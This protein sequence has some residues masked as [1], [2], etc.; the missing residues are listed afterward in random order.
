MSTDPASP[1]PRAQGPLQNTGAAAGFRVPDLAPL[2]VPRP[3]LTAAL[4]RA[5]GVPLVLVSGPAGSG[6]TSLV[7]EWL[8]HGG[9]RRDAI[10]WV[11]FEDEDTRLWQPLLTALVRLGL[12]LPASIARPVPDQLLGHTRLGALATT[13]A[14]S[15]R[16]WTVVLDGYELR[17]AELAEEVD[18]LLHHSY[19]ALR[20]VVAA[21]V[22]PVLPLYRYRLAEDLVEVRAGDLAFTDEEAAELLR[23]CGTSLGTAGVRALNRRL[24]GWAAGLRFAAR[25]LAAH[26]RPAETAASAIAQDADINAYLVAEVLDGLDPEDRRLLMRTC[27]PD[28]LRPGLAEELAGP[29]AGRELAVL[30]QANLF[31]EPVPEEPGCFRYSPFFRD[32]LRAQLAAEDL[33][34]AAV[35]HRRAATWL[36]EHRMP[37][38]AVAQ[39]A[40]GGLWSDVADRIVEDLLVPGL[41]VGHDERLVTIA[42]EIPADL[43]GPAACAVRAALAL[44]AAD[45]DATAAELGRARA[46]DGPVSHNLSLALTLIDM[47]RG[48]STDPAA[49]AE[50]LVAEARV[51]LDVAGNPAASNAGPGPIAL[52]D[53]AAAIIGLRQGHLGLARAALRRVEDVPGLPSRLGASVLGHRALTDALDGLLTQARR[54]AVRAVALMD[55]AQVAVADRNAAAYVALAVVALERDDLAATAEHLAAARACRSLAAHPVCRTVASGVAAHLEA[56]TRPAGPVV[57]RLVAVSA[58]ALDHDPW[59]AG[60]LRLQAAQIA[61]AHGLADRAVE[62]LDVL[63]REA[64]DTVTEEGLGGTVIAAAASAERAAE[65]STAGPAVHPTL[66]LA[67]SS[68]VSRPLPTEVSR[69]LVEA[70]HESRGR[71][72]QRAVTLVDSALRLASHEQLRRPFREAGPSVRRLLA[73]HP[74]L[75]RRHRWLVPVRVPA[76]VPGVAPGALAGVSSATVPPGRRPPPRAT[77][78]TPPVPVREEPTDVAGLV[79][80]PLTAKEREVLGHLEELLTTEEMAEKMFV[81]VNTIRTHVRSILR[82]L[83]VNRRNSAVRRARELGLLDHDE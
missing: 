13:L 35:L 47:V 55:D 62:T 3:R 10:A 19:G 69:L 20:L 61:L 38:R 17:S 40:A 75:V 41:L 24:N 7:V 65:A 60:W 49:S 28:V 21:R 11:T 18:H 14:S 34:G 54:R 77:R 63:V 9:A 80:E 15:A 46:A 6:K 58:L 66:D 57:D 50:R 74:Q 23:A 72:P 31:L 2:H 64:S 67:P 82:K 5:S 30:A 59:L 12:R 43:P 8:R 45:L 29:G 70:L 52:V 79:T 39:L 48:C 42:R 4:D 51:A 68:T 25:D 83:G 1:A 36:R 44:A 78:R 71:S 16:R 33:A 76:R 32:L 22:D 81:S 26:D 73:S 27:V 53:L 37:A 56:T